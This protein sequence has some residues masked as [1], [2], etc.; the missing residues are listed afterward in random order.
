MNPDEPL[1][2]LD[3][4]FDRIVRSVL[5]GFLHEGFTVTPVDPGDLLQARR[6]PGCSMRCALLTP[7][8]LFGRGVTAGAAAPPS[9]R[10]SVFELNGSCTL[11]TA[12]NRL[13]RYLLAS[14]AGRNSDGIGD[15]LR[16]IL[17]DMAETSA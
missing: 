16:L 13:A 2:V 1:L 4:P 12:E 8:C 11:V 9:C 7:P 15:A 10:V 5:D 3:R 14:L 6:H 17:R